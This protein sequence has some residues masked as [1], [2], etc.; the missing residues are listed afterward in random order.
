MRYVLIV[1]LIFA[2]P[3]ATCADENGIFALGNT[4]GDGALIYPRDIKE[5]PDDRIYA[6]DQKDGYIKTYSNSGEYLNRFGGKGEGPGEIKR[7]GGV[8]IGF[9]NTKKLFF[10]EY[11]RGHRWITIMNL[12]GSVH[13]TLPLHLE[14]KM[15]GVEKAFC[16][17]DGTFLV[18]VAFPGKP[19][20]RKKYYLHDSPL[21]IVRVSSEGKILSIIKETN[22]F[23]RLSYLQ[24]GG[25]LGLPFAPM[26]QWR[27]FNEKSILFSDSTDKK[28]Q[29]LDYEGKLINEV[30][31]SLPDADKVTS[32]DLNEWRDRR[33]DNFS[34]KQSYRDW[35]EKFGKVITEY[36]DSI[37]EKKPILENLSITPGSNILVARPWS[38]ERKGGE[39]W[40]ISGEGVTLAKIF[41]P[42]FDMSISK[43]FIFFIRLDDDNNQTVCCYIRKGTEVQDFV[44]LEK[45]LK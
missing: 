42:A 39:F 32:T 4:E 11:I 41:M 38:E 3:A 43:S 45:K 37:Y 36:R 23:T 18:E 35:Y 13:Q 27:P 33:K 30:R 29:V 20:K 9:T 17:Q 26:T 1:L 6:Y 5:G 7:T 31:T 10:T 15:F 21:R 22:Y 14:E 8:N 34:D 44:N 16:L 24:R 12:D 19:T 40:L 28:F 25:D 2:V